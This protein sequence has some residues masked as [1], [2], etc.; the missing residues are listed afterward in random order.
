[1]AVSIQPCATHSV[2]LRAPD[3]RAKTLALE[4]ALLSLPRNGNSPRGHLDT[5][6]RLVLYP[7]V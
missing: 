4:H 3:E 6:H 7:V 1:M 5:E 2:R